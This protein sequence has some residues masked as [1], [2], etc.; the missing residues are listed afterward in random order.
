MEGNDR[1]SVSSFTVDQ[2]YK[3]L[4]LKNNDLLTFVDKELVDFDLIDPV[5]KIICDDQSLCP[6]GSQHVACLSNK[7]RKPIQASHT[8]H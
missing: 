4:Y 5:K 2:M 3:P 6:T 1:E 8:G 7:R